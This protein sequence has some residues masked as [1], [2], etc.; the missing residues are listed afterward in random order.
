[1]KKIILLMVIAVLLTIPGNAQMLCEL[2]FTIYKDDTVELNKIQ[3]LPGVAH[4]IPRGI[5]SSDY[6][7]HVLDSNR[8]IIKEAHLPVSFLLLSDPPQET[9]RSR[10]WLE[11]EYDSSWRFLEIYHGDSRI[12]QK[13]MGPLCNGDSR[14]DPEESW[15]SCPGDCPSGSEDGWCDRVNDGTCDPDCMEGADSDCE[16]GTTTVRGLGTTTVRELGTT[17]PATTLPTTVPTTTTIEQQEG[18]GLEGYLPYLFGVIILV[19]IAVVVL[20]SS[21]LRRMDRKRKEEKEKLGNWVEGQLRTGEDPELLKKALKK[22]GAEP[23][24]VDEVMKKL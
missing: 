3:V 14:C 24:M 21:Q 7:L 23:A 19:V 2:E 16:L 18:N 12:F 6:V 8:N 9:D 22:Q 15:I 5:I 17:T 20:R 10:T 4:E 1:M 13:D 11:L